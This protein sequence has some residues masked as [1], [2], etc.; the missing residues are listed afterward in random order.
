ME[1]GNQNKIRGGGEDRDVGYGDGC[2]QGMV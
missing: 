1:K 2:V